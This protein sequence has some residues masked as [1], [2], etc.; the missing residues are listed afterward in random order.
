MLCSY[1]TMV[2]NQMGQRM[3]ASMCIYVC[4]YNICARRH[5]TMSLE[6]WAKS[7]LKIDNTKCVWS[8][9]SLTGQFISFNAILIFFFTFNFQRKMMVN[10]FSQFLCH[11]LNDISVLICMAKNYGES[12]VSCNSSGN[13]LNGKIG[14]N[15]VIK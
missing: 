14:I 12:C 13:Y 2:R 3:S 4:M 5:L 10:I 7:N 1:Y 8:D 11:H 6:N 15:I 9:A